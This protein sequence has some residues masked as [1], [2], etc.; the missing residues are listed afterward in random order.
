MVTPIIQ[1]ITYIGF[2]LDN[3]QTQPSNAQ[4][5]PSNATIWILRCNIAENYLQMEDHRIIQR[6]YRL[7]SWT[8]TGGGV[9]RVGDP[10]PLPS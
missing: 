10:P 5:Q 4:T 2:D 6:Q 9:A 7:R 3:A 8:A 1:C